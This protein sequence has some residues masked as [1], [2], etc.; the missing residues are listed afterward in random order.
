MPFT[1]GAVS[2]PNFKKWGPLIAVALLVLIPTMME[3]NI[4]LSQN[5]Y[6]SMLLCFM[7]IYTI[8]TSGL[9]ILFGYAGQISFGHAGFF[10]IGAY[11]S[12]LL[13]HPQWGISQWLGFTLPPIVSLFVVALIAALFGILLSFPAS[14]LVFHFLALLT[15]AF[16]QLMFLVVTN[17]PDLN[18][19]YRG[20]TNIPPVE[21]FGISFIAVS[22]KYM[23]YLLALFFTV[24]LLIIKQNIIKSR[25]GRGFIAIR[26]NIWAANGCGVNVRYYKML[27]FGISAFYTGFAGALYAHMV[28]FISP[29]PFVYDTSVIFVTMLLFGGSGSI[30]GPILG[31]VVIT[32]I[33]EGLQWLADYRMLIY[34]AFLLAIILFQPKGIAGLG[35]S[36]EGLFKKKGGEQS[37]RN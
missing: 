15:I 17:F 37:A 2:K 1:P 24:A 8:A 21:V 33:Q 11:G 20:I 14:K 10:C 36:I 6:V 16:G 31:A 34:G 29:D 27:A 22:N 32:L 18:N 3:N 23:Y 4:L 30:V 5:K 26:E 13:T 9:D 12:V 28:G 7:C 19:A 25:V 35:A